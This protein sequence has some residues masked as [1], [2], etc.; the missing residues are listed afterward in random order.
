MPACPHLAAGHVTVGAERARIACATVFR[1]PDHVTVAVADPELATRFFELLGFKKGHV[2][3]I[4]GDAPAKYMG[5]PDMKVEHITLVL[6]GARPASRSSCWRSIRFRAPIWVS[7]RRAFVDG[8][9]TTLP[10]GSTTSPPPLPISRPM[11]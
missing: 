8:A 5:M 9:T 3:I 4:D 2:A 1:N 7:I 10:F 6:E 11:A